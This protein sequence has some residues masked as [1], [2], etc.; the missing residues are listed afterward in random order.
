M[1]YKK[2]KESLRMALENQKIDQGERFSIWKVL[3]E[4][5]EK[6]R[7][8]RESVNKWESVWSST[9]HTNVSFTHS[10]L[11]NGLKHSAGPLSIP[12]KSTEQKNLK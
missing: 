8:D 12:T 4:V 7:R 1:N 11:A 5:K 9:K 6:E 10:F 3:K 2:A